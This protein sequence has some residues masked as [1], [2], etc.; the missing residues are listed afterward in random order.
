MFLQLVEANE[1]SKTYHFC[2]F[3]ST[4]DLT[5]DKQK[6]YKCKTTAESPAFCILVK[7]F[8]KVRRELWQLWCF[9]KR[10]A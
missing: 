10:E 2:A 6:L 5:V 3:S 9:A 4:L 7:T 1:S 8:I